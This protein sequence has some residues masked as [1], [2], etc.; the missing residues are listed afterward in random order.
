MLVLGVDPGSIVTG[1][2][3]VEKQDTKLTYVGGSSELIRALS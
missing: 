3:L 2:G 1:Y